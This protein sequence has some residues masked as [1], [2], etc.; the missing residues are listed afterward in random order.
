[1]NLVVKLGEVFVIEKRF[2]E[3]DF[4]LYT[5]PFPDESSVVVKRSTGHIKAIY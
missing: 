1:M 3:F 2:I 4:G 5:F